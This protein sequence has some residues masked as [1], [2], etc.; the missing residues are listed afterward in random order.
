MDICL[1][2]IN[3]SS[4]T[5]D[6]SNRHWRVQSR[7]L[8]YQKFF[9]A[10]CSLLHLIYILPLAWETMFSTHAK[11]QLRVPL[12]ILGAFAKRKR[13]P[14]QPFFRLS[15]GN[16][17]TPIAEIFLWNFILVNFTNIFSM[18]PVKN[19]TLFTRDGLCQWFSQLWGALSVRYEL[20]IK[21][22]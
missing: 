11:Q 20:K 17:A 18:W 6:S 2:R 3:S 8:Y 10:P 4:Q 16:G 9:S 21:I 7:I 15:A 14:V 13:L 1:K 5:L 22:S 19:K 12:R